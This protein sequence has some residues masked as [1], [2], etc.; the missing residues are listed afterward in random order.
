MYENEVK[1]QF[2]SLIRKMM[3]E[4]EKEVDKAPTFDVALDRV[5]RLVSSRLTAAGRGYLSSLYDALSDRT[6]AEPIFQNPT[7]ANK[8]YAMDLD[9]KIVSAYKLDVK[10][11]D[12]YRQ[13][14][15]F[16]EVKRAYA[17]A[18]GA[19]GSAVVGAAGTLAVKAILL[20]VLVKPLN[21]PFVVVIAGALLFALAGGIVTD[22]V[23]VPDKNKKRLKKSLKT[24]MKGLES[25][26]HDWIDAV[27]S[28]YNKEVDVLKATLVE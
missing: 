15:G 18:I 22:K 3:S 12:S 23:I 9:H 19:L 8:F 4:L 20:R 1:E 14:I 21:I 27:V 11:L 16:N 28:F 13:G 5:M 10:D 6:L 7:N 17:I 2:S 26:L 24:F 25:D